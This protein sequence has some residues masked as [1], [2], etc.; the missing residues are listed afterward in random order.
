MS[1]RDRPCH[2]WHEEDGPV[3]EGRP[4][5][6]FHN[7]DYRRDEN[8]PPYDEGGELPP[9]LYQFRGPQ[10]P[11]DG[12][13]VEAWRDVVGTVRNG[14]LV[15]LAAALDGTLVLTSNMPRTRAASVLV[16]AAGVLRGDVQP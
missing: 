6:D 16:R 11:V 2:A 5:N 1:E 7:G 12:A 14:D 13:H 15:I 8:A 4:E 3:E 10:S 9:G